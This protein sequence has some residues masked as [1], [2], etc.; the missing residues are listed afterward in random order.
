MHTQ[1]PA[2]AVRSEVFKAEAPWM[3]HG[4]GDHVVVGD[5]ETLITHGK[6]GA[7]KGAA[8]RVTEESAHQHHRFARRIQPHACGIGQRQFC[9]VRLLDLLGADQLAFLGNALLGGSGR[10]RIGNLRLRDRFSVWRGGGSGVGFGSIRLGRFLA[11]LLRGGCVGAFGAVHRACEQGGHAGSGGGAERGTKDSSHAVH[12]SETGPAARTGAVSRGGAPQ[13][14]SKWCRN[15]LESSPARS[16]IAAGYVMR[17]LMKRSPWRA[18]I[19][20]ECSGCSLPWNSAE[21]TNDTASAL[22]SSGVT[23]MVLRSTSLAPG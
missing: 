6:A 19:S 10:R 5:D 1:T 17:Y 20:S 2:A 8:G 21:N 18:R 22:I 9:Q 4:L 15:L 13:G 11:G 7:V 12:L 23:W 3:Q 16:A 14:Q